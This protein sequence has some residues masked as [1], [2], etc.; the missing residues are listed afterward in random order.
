MSSYLFASAAEPLDT[1]AAVRGW[2]DGP[3]DLCVISPSYAAEETAIFVSANHFVQIVEEPLLAGR[4]ST[5][6][7]DDF[8]ARFAEALRTVLAYD[9]RAVLVV[10]DELPD[11]WAVPFVGSS[12]DVEARADLL[13]RALPLP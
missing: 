1:A 12:H 5:E 7:A 8:V 3:P 13:E 9:G 11:E 10:C 4:G 2:E 6:S